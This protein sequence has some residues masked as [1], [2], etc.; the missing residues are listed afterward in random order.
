M[1]LRVTTESD[2]FVYASS[3]LKIAGL[4]PEDFVILVFPIAA[5]NTVGVQPL[6]CLFAGGFC[7]WLYKQ[8]TAEQPPGFLPILFSISLGALYNSRFIQSV[9]P[10]RFV[11]HML[12][13]GINNLWIACGLLPLPSYCNRYER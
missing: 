1:D 13:K 8:A 2:T 4:E 10:L 3:T 6:L 5:L 9:K 12:V 11:M 7:L